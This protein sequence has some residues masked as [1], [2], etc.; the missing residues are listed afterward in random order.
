M[1]R[2]GAR[3]ARFSFCAVRALECAA[4]GRSTRALGDRMFADAAQRM[5]AQI[6]AANH[7]S[8][9][10]NTARLFMLQ[11]LAPI[12]ESLPAAGKRA[13]MTSGA[14][15]NGAATADDLVAA[16]VA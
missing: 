9:D 15:A 8:S 3:P 16:R 11:A 14:F 10:F 13:L 7:L 2:F 6:E 5:L 1:R 12:A 4:A